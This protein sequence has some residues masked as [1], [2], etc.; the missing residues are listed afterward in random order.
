MLFQ[1]K[2][3]TLYAKVACLLTTNLQNYHAADNSVHLLSKKKQILFK[4]KYSRTTHSFITLNVMNN[5]N[6]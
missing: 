6:R 4:E 3:F 5:A 2:Y 1:Q